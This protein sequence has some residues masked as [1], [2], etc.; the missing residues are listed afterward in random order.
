MVKSKRQF[1]HECTSHCKKNYEE[2]KAIPK[3]KSIFD[4]VLQNLQRIADKFV[5]AKVIHEIVDEFNKEVF[6]HLLVQQ[7][8]PCKLGCTACCHTQISVTADEAQ[9]LAKRVYE[10]GRSIDVCLNFR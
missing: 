8:S 1:A 9:L 7:L 6:A 4:F 2:H 5:R 10:G 3:Y